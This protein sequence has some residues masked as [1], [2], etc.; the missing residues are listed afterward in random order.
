[1]AKHQDLDWNLRK[2]T[3]LSDDLKEEIRDQFDNVMQ[4]MDSAI[5][6]MN[7]A[8]GTQPVNYDD[9]I[10]SSETNQLDMEAYFHGL[11]DAMNDLRQW[12]KQQKQSELEQFVDGK[13]VNTDVKS[14]AI[15]G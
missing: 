8:V 15:C 9:Y 5:W 1:M 10:H 12:A 13:A 7:D 6:D 4:H 14:E 2:Y 11:C 3:H